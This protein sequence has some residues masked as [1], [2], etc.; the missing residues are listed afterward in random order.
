MISDYF[1]Y[2]QTKVVKRQANRDR[3]NYRGLYKQNLF[4][5]KSTLEKSADGEKSINQFRIFCGFF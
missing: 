2:L 1:L 5:L 4:G 3:T